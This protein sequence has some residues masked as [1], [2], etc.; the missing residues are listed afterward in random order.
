MRKAW[1]EVVAEQSAKSPEFKK[2]WASYSKFRDEYKIWK[3]SCRTSG[4][5]RRRPR[6]R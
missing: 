3:Q 6:K 1:D 2:A 5:C 4:H